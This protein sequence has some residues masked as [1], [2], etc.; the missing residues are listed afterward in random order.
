MVNRPA[1]LDT[2]VATKLHADILS[3]LAAALA[4]SLGIAPTGNIDPE[5]RYPSMF[6]PIHGSAFDIMGQGLA[7]PLGTFWSVVLMLEH[8]GEAAAAQR[9]MRA[10]ED[11]TANP[12]LHT[13]DLGGTATTRQVTAAVCAAIAK[14]STPRRAA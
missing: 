14:N 3:D 5:R 8:L 1:S 11:V 7:N 10:I 4:G 2:I 9:V 12:A 6:E 13:R